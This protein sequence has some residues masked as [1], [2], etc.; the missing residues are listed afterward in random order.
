MKKCFLF[1]FVL[2]LSLNY[3]GCVELNKQAW[4]YSVEEP[5]WIKN[6]E[7]IIFENQKWYPRDIIETLLDEEM[8][9]IFTYN[10]EKIYIEKKEVRP[11][12]RL[13]TKFG[14]LKYRLFEK[15]D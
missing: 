12:N 5:Q 3:S 13:Y 6:G 4:E 15:N 9:N 10:G 14:K 8:F 2:L 1:I 7:P 11:Y